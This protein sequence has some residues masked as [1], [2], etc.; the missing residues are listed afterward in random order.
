MG[1]FGTPSFKDAR[2]DLEASPRPQMSLTSLVKQTR[3]GPEQFWV[4]EA[5][6]SR[7]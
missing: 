5:D 2:T 4:Q 3:E 1:R 6:V 7:P